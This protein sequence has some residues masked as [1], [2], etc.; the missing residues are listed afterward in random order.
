MGKCQFSYKTLSKQLHELKVVVHFDIKL[1]IFFFNFEQIFKDLLIY[2]FFFGG[3]HNYGP[4]VHFILWVT[5]T[6]KDLLKV[7]GF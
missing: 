7:N 5:Q 1:V 4:T 2:L 3:F 6:F